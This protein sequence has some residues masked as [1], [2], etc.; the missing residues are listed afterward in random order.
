MEN[1]VLTSS[2]I[3]FLNS[4]SSLKNI[5]I[6]APFFR[7]FR[8]QTWQNR[9]LNLIEIKKYTDQFKQMSHDSHEAVL[10]YDWLVSFSSMA[11]TKITPR[12]GDKKKTKKVKTRAEV[13]AAPV[14][15]PLLMEPPVLI[16]RFLQLQV[17]WKGE[18]WRCRSWGRWRGHWSSLT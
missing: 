6:F 4:L 1:K 7:H 16:W 13:H 11:I 2:C 15:P 12:N 8:Q 14:E 9:W 10:A 17:K 3:A 5:C 18:G